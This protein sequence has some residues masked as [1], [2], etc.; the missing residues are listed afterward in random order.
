[1]L[2]VTYMH[3]FRNL[4]TMQMLLFVDYIIPLY[5]SRCSSINA[6]KLSCT[7]FDFCFGALTLTIR[8]QSS[9]TFTDPKGRQGHASPL[10][11]I[12][13]IFLQCLWNIDQ[14]KCS[15]P[16]PWWL[17]PSLKNPGLA[18]VLHHLNVPPKTNIKLAMT[19]QIRQREH[20]TVHFWKQKQ[21]K[22][23]EQNDQMC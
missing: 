18:T 8:Y 11:P 19:T 15:A 22:R 17:P 7:R 13:F 23:K 14:S 5:D 2:S 1:M 21:Y 16:S 10:G 6:K 12:F 9:F 4:H 20:H 3:N